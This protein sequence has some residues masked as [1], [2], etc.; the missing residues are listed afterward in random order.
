MGWVCRVHLELVCSCAFCFDLFACQRRVES[1]RPNDFRRRCH[2]FRVDGNECPVV[3]LA[4][5][6]IPWLSSS[7]IVDESLLDP[8]V[9]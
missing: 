9:T 3:G 2:S 6:G 4:A 7:T 1:Q 8:L 5:L